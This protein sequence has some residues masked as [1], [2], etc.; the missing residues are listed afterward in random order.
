MI[1]YLYA[2]VFLILGSNL[3]AQQT[4][5]CKVK[6]P[7]LSGSYSGECKKGLAH[8]KGVAQGIDHYEGQFFKGMPEGNGTYKWANGSRYEGAWKNGIREG[9]GKYISGDTVVTG[10]WKANRYQGKVKIP[11]YKITANRNIQ[12][13]TITKSVETSNG[14][15][16]KLMLGG[17]ENSEV[18]DFTLAGTSGS[19]YRNV[20]TYG[21]QNSSLP[22]EVTV[23]YKTW[24]QLH[25]AQYDVFFE[26]VIIDPGTWNITLINM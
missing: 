10:Y 3:Y 26:V 22:L 12:R 4:T 14:V 23:R 8:G 5:D 7:A 17:V 21:I 24:N 6:L 15:T 25:T 18:E 2:A 13:W 20:G 19:E 16:I 9:E 11:S 1:K